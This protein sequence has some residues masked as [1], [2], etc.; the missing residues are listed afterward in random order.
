MTSPVSPQA[1]SDSI[2]TPRI[3]AQMM[4]DGHPY[5]TRLNTFISPEEMTKDP[6]FFESRDLGGRVERP[7][8]RPSGRCAATRST[9]PATPRSGSSCPTGACSGC[10]AG[11]KA[12]TCQ[13]TAPTVNGLAS[14]PGGRGRLP[15]RGGRRRDAR[16]RQ[17]GGD[18]GR[19]RG[20]Q[21]LVPERADAVPDPDG[22]RWLDRRRRRRRRE[23]RLGRRRR[24]RMGTAG[25]GGNGRHGEQPRGER[26]DRRPVSRRRRRRQQRRRLRLCDRRLRRRLRRARPRARRIVQ[27][28]APAPRP[29][30]A[31]R[32]TVGCRRSRPSVTLRPWWTHGRRA[33]T[34]P[35]G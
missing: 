14:L 11:S 15:A 24:R 21:R 1:I 5:L 20:Q 35:G 13:S 33:R 8:R 32:L 23:S 16:P 9:W 3:N 7:H 10:A 31:P 25:W 17:H 12:A 2:V 18:R 26:R 22:N 4:I 28:I 34:I 27:P 6:F 19:D 29:P 30:R